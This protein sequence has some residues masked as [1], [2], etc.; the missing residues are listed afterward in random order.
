MK[1]KH[2][3]VYVSS[4]SVHIPHGLMCCECKKKDENCSHLPFDKMIPI[5]DY[6]DGYKAVRCKEL[7]K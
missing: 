7:V 5:L 3:E 4:T 2:T 6:K 1:N